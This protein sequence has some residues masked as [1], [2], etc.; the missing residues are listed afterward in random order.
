MFSFFQCGGFGHLSLTCTKPA[1]TSKSSARRDWLEG[2]LLTTDNADAQQVECDFLDLK[3]APF[4]VD[5][6]LRRLVP[7]LLHL[8]LESRAPSTVQKYRS[9][10]LTWRQW[11]APKIVV[12]VIPAKPLSAS[13]SHPLR[14]LEGNLHVPFSLKSLYP[15]TQFVGSLIIIFLVFLSPL[16]VFFSS[17][18]LAS[19]GFTEWAKFVLCLLKMSLFAVN[20]CQV[21]FWKARMISIGRGIHPS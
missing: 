15:S 1:D 14:A 2:G 12:Q 7:N 11:S 19:L 16:F 9:S 21:S 20:T 13:L 18:W 4:T 3:K 8:R 5:L 6:S 10:W 17:S